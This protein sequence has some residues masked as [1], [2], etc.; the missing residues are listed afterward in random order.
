MLLEVDPRIGFDASDQRP[1]HE[2]H[3][4]RNSPNFRHIELR[5]E[6]KGIRVTHGISKQPGIELFEDVRQGGRI[7]K[8][9]LP[10]YA[11]AESPV[12]DE[13]IHEGG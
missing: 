3:I 13:Q 8:A 4:R 12:V 2:G 6:M 1:G 5:G 10:T 7:A 11:P 9:P